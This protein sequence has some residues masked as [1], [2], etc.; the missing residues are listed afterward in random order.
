MD[1]TNRAPRPRRRGSRAGARAGCQVKIRADDRAPAAARRVLEDFATALGDGVLCNAQLLATELVTNSVRHASLG[2]DAS[3]TLTLSLSDT[4]LRVAVSNPGRGFEANAAP[5]PTGEIPHG[6]RGL[7][8]L[9]GRAQRWGIDNS[10][11]TTVWFELPRWPVADAT[12]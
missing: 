8:L 10:V 11:D 3:I 6:G 9:E 7:I 4:V 2:P 1:L 12:G 5:M